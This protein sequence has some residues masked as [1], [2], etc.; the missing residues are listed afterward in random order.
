MMASFEKVDFEIDKI[1]GELGWSFRLASSHV[2]LLVERC[3]RV[4]EFS[5]LYAGRLRVEVPLRG[6]VVWRAVL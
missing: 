4:L 3:P 1:K 5:V 2:G 6:S